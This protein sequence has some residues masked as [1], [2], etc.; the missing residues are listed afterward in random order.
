[1]G[2]KGG[3]MLHPYEDPELTFQS[4]IDMF[5]HT[6]MGGL[7]GTIKRDGQ[8]LVLS[9]SLL[10]DEA[11][12][13][14]NDDHVFAKGMGLKGEGPKENFA[15]YLAARSLWAVL[16][17]PDGQ[18]EEFTTERKWEKYLKENGT[19]PEALEAA[20]YSV[21]M[22]G[23]GWKSFRNGVGREKK[24]TP[25]HIIK[26]F[27]KA[28]RD[29]EN[30]A[31][32]M[33]EEL[34]IKLFGEDADY[35]YNAEVMSPLSRNAIEYGVDTLSTHRILHHKYDE[36]E[37]EL[38]TMGAI[39][40][41][42]RAELFDQALKDY[43]ETKGA[44]GDERNPT[45]VSVG[46]LERLAAL[47][48][49]SIKEKAINDVAKLAAVNNLSV[50]DS[51]GRLVF[52]RFR[53]AVAKA[54]PSIGPEAEKLLI[55]RMFQEVYNSPGHEWGADE[56]LREF[57]DTNMVE[58]KV[59]LKAIVAVS[60]DREPEV[61]KKIKEVAGSAKRFHNHI[62]APLVNIIFTF[63]AHA[64]GALEDLYVLSRDAEIERTR[65]TVLKTIKNLETLLNPINSSDPRAEEK[66]EKFLS[67]RDKFKALEDK[68]SE[69]EG[70]VFQWPPGSDNTYK[71]TGLFAPINQ[72]LGM[73]PSRWA[74]G[75]V[76]SE[77][78][79]TEEEVQEDLAI[80]YFPGG[81][82]PPHRGHLKTAVEALKLD[83]SVHL[84]IMT[85][86]SERDGITL[87]KSSQ[88]LAKYLEREGISMGVGKGQVEVKAIKPVPIFDGTGKQKT[89]VNKETGE[90]ELSTTTSP[91]AAIM[92][93][94]ERLP[95]GATA[96]AVASEADPTN[97]VA[98]V[99]YAGSK[100][101]DLNVQPIIIPVE[102]ME[103]FPKMSAT[104]MRRAI[105]ENDFETFKLF[106][107]VSYNDDDDAA[108]ELFAILGGNLQ[109]ISSMGGGSV[110]G[111]MIGT[112]SKKGPWPGFDSAGFNRRQAKDAKLR[113]AKEFISEEDKMVN[114]VMNY[115]LGISVG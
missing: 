72:L 74:E 20:G 36:E 89:R 24:A 29:L 84:I 108:Y 12:A 68:I 39:E 37:K 87:E 52:V 10:R 75:L 90:H 14:R 18:T 32:E 19:S 62:I 113:G 1:V 59:P 99:N 110:Q 92:Y 50:G 105:Q 13:I 43:Y 100:R 7:E 25:R 57:G 85:G 91:I 93:E 5:E 76:Y 73:D 97:A 33:P 111:A 98:V 16:T 46:A 21:E 60:A 27:S 44:P 45:P 80:A 58:A 69:A 107:P 49:D 61:A 104:Q 109:E 67:Q 22:I 115:L 63:S 26:A 9:Y 2:G 35:F 96:Y 11:V 55:I 40:S 103:G 6:A 114:E 95:E 78:L 82:K 31:R 94:I 3:H 81:F 8:N 54:L 77:T 34:I 66:W 83:P 79:L 42:K 86:E 64:L 51:L 30:V 65:G 102:E 71:F 17:S 88:V 48:D 106:L 28:M 15:D 47:E 112:G 41:G 53:E 38:D 23:R 101:P 56:V 4:L 70:F